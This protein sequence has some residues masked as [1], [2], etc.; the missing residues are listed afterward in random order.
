[1]TAPAQFQPKPDVPAWR[2]LLTLGLGGALAGFVL[3]FVYQLTLPVIERNKAER[4]AAAV[5]EVLKAPDHY[6][7]LYV[8]DGAL[9]KA[10]PA[11]TDPKK[12]ETLYLGYTADGSHIGFAI[13]SA[14][15]GFQD[16]VRLIFGYDNTTRTLLGMKVLESK[17]T[18]GLGDKIEKSEAFVSQFDGVAAPLKGVKARD[19][20][21]D[22]HE[23]DMI[24]GATI[25]SRAV[26][27]IINNALD[28]VGPLLDAYRASAAPPAGAEVGQ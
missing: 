20:T 11:G 2:L 15:P 24:T 1:V 25:S 23:V 27:R 3:V 9:T 19:G 28:R 12:L 18:P 14:E 10:L 7:T 13:A 21:G 6:D 16:Q 8:F 22:P 17:E 26:I 4:L 5:Q